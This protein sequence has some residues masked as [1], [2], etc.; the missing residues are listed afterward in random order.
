MNYGKE[1]GKKKT[2]I[3][4]SWK[5]ISL[6]ITPRTD[7]MTFNAESLY[8]DLS[9]PSRLSILYGHETSR[10]TASLSYLAYTLTV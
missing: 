3:A 2:F 9:Y 5:W 7:D 6:F 10:I 8:H 4:L 1:A